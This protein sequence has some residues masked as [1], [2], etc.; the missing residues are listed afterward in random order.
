M[1]DAG[2]MLHFAVRDTGIGLSEQGKGRLFQK[3]SQADSEHHAQVRRHRLGLAIRKLLAE[4]MGG[5]MWVESDGRGTGSTFHFHDPRRRPVRWRGRARALAG[6]A[7]RAGKRILVVD[8]NATNRRIL[9]LQT[10]RVGHG[11]GAGHGVAGHALVL[12]GAERFDLAISTCTCRA[13]TARRWRDGREAGQPLPLVLFHLAR[14]QGS[15]RDACSPPR[16]SKPLH[17]SHLFDTMA[18]GSQ[19]AHRARPRLPPGHAPPR[20]PSA[21]RCASRSPRRTTS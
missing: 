20:W 11:R 13:W 18:A 17:Q 16:W 4:L 21:I 9:T 2:T 14:P 8:D 1:G 7:H 5:A 3:F 19:D 10:A 15:R 6:A 12:L